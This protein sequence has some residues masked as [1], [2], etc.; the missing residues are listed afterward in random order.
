MKIS[1]DQSIESVLNSDLSLNDQ[2]QILAKMGYDDEEASLL[3]EQ[4]ESSSRLPV[5]YETLKEQDYDA[6]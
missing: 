5:Y 1:P 2:L 4:H 3:V 6:D